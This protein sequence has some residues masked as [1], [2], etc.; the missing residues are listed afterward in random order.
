MRPDVIITDELSARDCEALQ[1]AV[2]AGIK[3]VASAHFLDMSYI[4]VPFLGV[5][6]RYVF[7]KERIGHLVSIC[8]AQGKE[9]KKC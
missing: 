3:I 1:K 9:I 8:D 5:F 7:L 2:S 6:E 4:K